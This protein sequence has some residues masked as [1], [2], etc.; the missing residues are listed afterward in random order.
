MSTSDLAVLLTVYHKIAPADLQASLDSLRDQ[1]VQ[2]DEI[3]VVE[4]GPLTPELTAVLDA[5]PGLRRFALTENQGAARAS[6]RGLEEIDA[7]WLARQDADDISLPTRFEKQLAAA[8]ELGVDVLG[9]AALEF[10][11]DPDTPTAVRSL[12]TEHDAILRYARINNPINNPTLFART[13]A[14]RAVGGYR[15]V[16]FQEDYDLNIR[17]LGAGYRFHNLPEPLVKFRVTPEQ[18]TR[19][20][21]SGL[22]ASER[23]IQRTLVDAGLIS[24]PRAVVNFVV[25][26]TYR[27]L[28]MGAMNSAYKRL[29]HR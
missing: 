9:T 2:P 17:L 10:D 26:S 5:T 15:D 21:S 8:R 18:F 28:P 23:T 27:R 1:T 12:P 19:R 16:H 20:R 3:V 7:T 6:Q 4:D 24:K 11:A 13:A 29:F 14:L 25:R 22:S